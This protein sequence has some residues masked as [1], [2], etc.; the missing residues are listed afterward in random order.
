MPVGAE[1]HLH[2]LPSLPLNQSIGLRSGLVRRPAQH[3]DQR[4]DRGQLHADLGARGGR[5]NARSGR[6]GTGTSPCARNAARFAAAMWRLNAARAGKPP[7]DGTEVFVLAKP[8]LYEEKGEFQLIVSRM[9][10]T[11]G[12]R[13]EA[14]GA[15]AG[16][17]AAAAGRP[18]RSGAQACGAP[19]RQHHRGG[20]HLRTARRS[21]TW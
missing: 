13:P 21:R 12:G 1:S 8:G 18:L 4:A 20:D 7:A 6:V 11:S 3:R 15:G 14:A 5:C 10:P 2:D 19:V 17:G 16:E 9:L